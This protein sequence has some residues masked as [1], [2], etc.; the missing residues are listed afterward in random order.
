MRGNFRLQ[1]FLK[2]SKILH[3]SD[4]F[5]SFLKTVYTIEYDKRYKHKKYK[6]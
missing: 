6:Y 3:F 2:N 1:T 5:F 4:I